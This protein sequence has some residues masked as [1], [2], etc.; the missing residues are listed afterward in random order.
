LEALLFV[1]KK[2][3][4]NFVTLGPGRDVANAHGPESKEFFGSFF[5][6]RTASLP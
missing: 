2:K 3:Q 6:K 5:Q 4:K 1:N